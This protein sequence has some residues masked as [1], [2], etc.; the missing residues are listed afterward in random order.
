MEKLSKI[1]IIEDEPLTAYLQKRIIESF[2]VSHQVE[3]ACCGEEA[4]QFIEQAIK[5][6]HENGLPELIFLDLNMPFMDGYQFLEAYQKLEF[7]QK[8]TVVVAVLTTSFL[9]KD[10]NRVKKYG[11][12]DY[13]EKPLTEGRMQEL[14]EQHFGWEVE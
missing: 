5:D 6:E 10:K 3:I 7:S 4:I 1:L 11:I 2:K 14:M 9:H 12:K 8:D 13:I